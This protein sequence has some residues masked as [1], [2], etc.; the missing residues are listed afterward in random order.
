[1]A[2]RP[3]R[4]ETGVIGRG[5]IKRA[6]SEHSSDDLVCTGIGVEE[7]LGP[8]MAEQMRVHPYPGMAVDGFAD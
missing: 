5:R 8:G 4:F 3:R 2:N 1:M 6:M 7:E